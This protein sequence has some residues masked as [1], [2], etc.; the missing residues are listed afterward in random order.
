M[1]GP[2]GCRGSQPERPLLGY[3]DAPPDDPALSDSVH[4][5]FSQDGDDISKELWMTLDKPPGALLSTGFLVGDGE[6]R[7][8]S[9]QPRSLLARF[10]ERPQ[11]GYA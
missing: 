2:A 7:K 6:K 3:F 5:A 1:A 8:P 10:D 11:V 4:A 9:C